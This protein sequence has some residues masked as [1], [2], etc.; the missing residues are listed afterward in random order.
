MGM[1]KYLVD[2]WQNAKDKVTPLQKERLIKW[3]KQPAVVKVDKPT[4]LAS[5]R[6]LGYKAKQGFVIVRAR[7]EKGKRKRRSLPLG[8]KP[9][10]YGTYFTT[11]R[12]LQS[13]LEQRVSRKYPNLEVLNSYWVGD[14]SKHIWYEIILV[15][16]NHPSIQN[17]KDVRWITETPS[18]GRAERGLTPAGKK[19]RKSR[20]KKVKQ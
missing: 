6:K 2:F 12:N 8:R 16:P 3:R 5:A 10:R 14:D 13:I 19:S 4:R 1:Y 9:K 17:D 11:T 18:R 20:R 15:D 7:I